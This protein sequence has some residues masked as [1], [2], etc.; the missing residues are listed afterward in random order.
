MVSDWQAAFECL[1]STCSGTVELCPSDKWGCA[2]G[3]V[4]E[5]LCG[6]YGNGCSS[7]FGE[8]TLAATEQVVAALIATLHGRNLNLEGLASLRSTWE[9]L[10]IQPVAAH[11]PVAGREIY[12]VESGVHVDGILKDPTN[13]EPLPPEALGAQRAIILGKHSGRASIVYELSRLG[14]TNASD[15]LV[16]HLL[17]CVREEAAK[18]SGV[19]SQSRFRELVCQEITL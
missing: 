12:Y 8:G 16:R 5:W 7:L 18:S 9:S 17:A 13:Y 6:G 11:A 14:V 10:G 2:T 19:I 15:K 4:V 1:R 3:I